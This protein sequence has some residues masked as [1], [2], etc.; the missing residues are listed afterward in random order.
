MHIVA[1]KR[2]CGRFHAGGTRRMWRDEG[3]AEARPY[4]WLGVWIE[5]GAVAGDG[6]NPKPN[7]ILIVT[8]LYYSLEVLGIVAYFHVALSNWKI[9]FKW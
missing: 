9:C 3:R 8:C 1:W 4:E 5:R 2:P 7:F 6:H